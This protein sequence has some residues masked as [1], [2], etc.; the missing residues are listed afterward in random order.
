MSTLV[1]TPRARSSSVRVATALLALS[2]AGAG[3]AQPAVSAELQR[4]L[5]AESWQLD[6]QITFTGSSSG[7]LDGLLGPQTYSNSV[8]LE[9]TA[10]YA[11]GIRSE[12]ASLSMQKLT[13]GLAGASAAEA[14]KAMMDLIMQ[15]DT[16]TSWIS[17]PPIPDEN[18]SP[19]QQTAQMLA[20]M[21][22]PIGTAKIA[23]VETTRGDRLVSE[24]GTVFKQ[25]TRRTR[26]GTHNVVGGG[27]QLMLEL[28]AKTQRI[29]FMLPH[30]YTSEQDAKLAED[31]TTVTESPPGAA[32]QETREHQDVPVL[33][34][35]M[36]IVNASPGSGS[37]LIIDDAF[38]LVA[39]KI[40]GGGTVDAT[41][42]AIPGKLVYRYT[43]TPH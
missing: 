24:A 19:E 10:R 4:L 7:P 8:T 32:P 39:G 33:P 41:Y 25:T 3:S 42:G 34:V 13:A 28:N 11:I 5:G 26:S 2:L 27:V 21:T 18:A 38:T 43:L 20:Y 17:G 29:S 6:C 35:Q 37:G 15:T 12:G 22:Q 40:S 36:S 23:V 9:H 16:I 14:Q 1:G 30:S 31:T